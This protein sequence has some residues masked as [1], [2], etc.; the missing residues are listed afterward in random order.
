MKFHLLA[1]GLTL[2]AVAHGDSRC[3]YAAD[4]C[5]GAETCFDVE[6]GVCADEYDDAEDD[7][8]VNA[9]TAT[10]AAP[11][12]CRTGGR[13]K[14]KCNAVNFT[15]ATYVVRRDFVEAVFLQQWPLANCSGQPYP[16][17]TAKVQTSKCVATS[18]TGSF[19]L[20]KEEWSVTDAVTGLPVIQNK[21]T[22]VEF[23]NRYCIPGSEN[24]YGRRSNWA[25]RFQNIGTNTTYS[26]DANETIG[27]V[28]GTCNP[29]F[30]NTTRPDTNTGSTY[31]YTPPWTLSPAFFVSLVQPSGLNVGQRLIN[32]DDG[33]MYETTA[34]FTVESGACYDNMMYTGCATSK[35]PM[36]VQMRT[37]G[38]FADRTDRWPYVP[39]CNG[40]EYD[41]LYS[42]VGAGGCE[43]N[44]VL[45]D[46][47]APD[48][49]KQMYTS[50][51]VSGNQI[52]WTVQTFSDDFCEHVNDYL[53][54]L[55]N[56]QNFPGAVTAGA[57]LIRSTVTVV[58]AALL[59]AVLV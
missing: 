26:Y 56:F 27:G 48:S 38:R 15:D 59:A 52:T 8:C 19:M 18:S 13:V 47:A 28:S 57:G 16:A 53:D 36:L 7:S 33:D 43:S 9:P 54:G 39:G 24:P 14:Y 12:A 40:T 31:P 4:N 55:T 10:C 17:Q 32:Y 30:D 22:S 6:P 51:S 23:N 20:Y 25:E 29:T 2:V 34:T 46:P 50:C 5:T 1:V 49:V 21:Y 58:T 35:Q 44:T 37:S 3:T 45:V 11:N 41:R 42:V